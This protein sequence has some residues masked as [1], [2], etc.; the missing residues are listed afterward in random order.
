MS[1]IVAA[2]TQAIAEA[3]FL[4]KEGG[5]VGMPTETVYGIGANALDGTAVAKIFAAKGRPSFN[6]LIAHF[7]SIIQAQQFVVF[8]DRAQMVAQAFWPGALTLIL[9][10]KNNTPLS[11]LATAG[12]DTVAVRVPNHDVALDLLRAVDFPIVAPSANKSGSLSPTTPAHVVESL[13]DAV[14]MILAAGACK[15]G[16]ES[17]VL[18][19]SS[20]KPIIL[21]PGAITAEDLADVLGEPVPYAQGTDDGAIKSPGMLLKHY[22]PDTPVRLNAIDLAPGEALLAFG[23]DKFMG[24]KGGGAASSLPD[25]MRRN[26]SEEGDLHQAAAN[27]FAMLKELDGAKASAIAVMNIPETGLG[28]AINDRLRRAAASG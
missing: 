11:E 18:D 4:L 27:L 22:A 28:V 12:L 14:E 26:L 5:L 8:N 20:G 10:K 15:V 2:S 19:L 3:A 17:T 9:P 1:R 7:H 21:R 25:D 13:G 16:L 23:S 6:P 24:I